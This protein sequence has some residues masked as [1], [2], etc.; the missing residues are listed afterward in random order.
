MQSQTRLRDQVAELTAQGAPLAAV[1]P[2]LLERRTPLVLI[3]EGSDGQPN[4]AVQR[5]EILSLA[6]DLGLV[7]GQAQQE[8]VQA[9]TQ[10][11][12]MGAS[13]APAVSAQQGELEEFLA[14]HAR[15]QDTHK[16]MADTPDEAERETVLARYD[17]LGE[18]YG[19]YA[20]KQ[21][22]GHGWPDMNKMMDRINA[23][24]RQGALPTPVSVPQGPVAPLP[25]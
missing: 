21:W 11:M 15:V 5:Q 19:S 6:Q 12:T 8:T 18:E 10:G 13:P 25:T 2:G 4:D 3:D 22:S 24:V 17:E 14:L 16:F 1:S 20:S 23:L 9:F 7:V